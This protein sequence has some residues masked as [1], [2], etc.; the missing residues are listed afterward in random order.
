MIALLCIIAY[1]VFG[2]LLSMVGTFLFKRAKE[3][4]DDVKFFMEL[5]IILWPL[6][7]IF[8]I[9]SG[10]FVGLSAFYDWFAGCINEKDKEK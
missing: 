9:I 8:F 1:I 4:D 6:H 3:W 10:I 2:F 5:C 7:I